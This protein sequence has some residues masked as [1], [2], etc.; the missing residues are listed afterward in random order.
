MLAAG[1]A[2]GRIHLALEPGILLRVAPDHPGV[3]SMHA[4]RENPAMPLLRLLAINCAAGIAVALLALG[5]LLAISPQLRTLI[6]SDHSPAVPIALLG[7]GF[8]VTF[9]SVVMGTAIWRIGREHDGPPRGGRKRHVS[10]GA[11][12]AP[13]R[14][15]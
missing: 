15:R 3:A 7:G 11:E 10:A 5:G 14:V 9:A 12:P 4:P 1:E 6:F 13:I 8:I 2:K